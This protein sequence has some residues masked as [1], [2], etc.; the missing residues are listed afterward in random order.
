MYRCIVHHL[1]FARKCGNRFEGGGSFKSTFLCRFF[2]NLTV[3]KITKIGPSTVADVLPFGARGP[4]IMTHR[5]YRT[6]TRT[7]T[8]TH[9]PRVGSGVVRIDPLRFLT[10]CRERRLNQALSVLSLSLG[11][12]WGMCCAVIYTD[13]F[14]V[15]LFFMLFVCSVTWLFLLGCQ[16]QCK[17]LTGK[18]R[19]R[20]NL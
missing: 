3:K 16:C 19:L 7:H 5:V 6:C 15:V 14:Y 17:W 20:N 4:V 12:F 2:L 8:R 9:T 18:T 13:S 1:R 11:F 10:R